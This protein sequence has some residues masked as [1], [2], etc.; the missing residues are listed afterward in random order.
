MDD[1]VQFLRARFAE[2]E[3]CARRSQLVDPAPWRAET[4]PGRPFRDQDRHKGAEFLAG[5]AGMVID[6]DGNDLWDCEGASSLSMT[7][8]SAEHAARHNPARVLAEVD[9]KRQLLQAHGPLNVQG[10][11]FT[12]CTTCSWRDQMDELWVQYPC[13]TLRLLALP[14][15]DHPDYREQWRPGAPGEPGAQDGEHEFHYDEDGAQRCARCHLP[16]AHWSGGPCPGS[17]QD[18]G[19]GKYV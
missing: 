3:W 5:T 14:Y 19:P 11:P 9:A 6:R 1:L 7:S 10:D 18:W 2:D 15:A 13:P 12:G 16:H 17:P 4:Y 8:E